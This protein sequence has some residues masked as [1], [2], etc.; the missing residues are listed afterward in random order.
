MEKIS[1]RF[2][3]SIAIIKLE[4]GKANT[5]TPAFFGE[6]NE[7]LDQIEA[8]GKKML[9]I[10]GRKGF[11]SGGLDLKLMSTIGPD[12]LIKLVE[13]FAKTLLRIF[14]YP[15]PTMAACTGHAVAGGAM[16][17]FACDRRF[18]VDGPYRFQV[19]ETQIGIPLPY[20][21]LLLGSSA[22]P[23][24]WQV[25]TLLHARVFS[26]S[27]AFDKGIFDSL[28]SEDTDIVSHIKESAK[29]IMNLNLS[30]YALSKKRM[31]ESKVKQ[32]LEL[33]KDELHPKES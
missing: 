7:A 17:A 5:M 30:A 26:L 14:L 9:I 28:V 31:R 27:E 13:T 1:L 22:V 2:E 15:I 8:S 11:F 19:N 33:L 29:N 18:A 6:L 12:E 25:E 10:E 3:D 23:S 4:D 16:L 21:M 20:W 24:R 32:V